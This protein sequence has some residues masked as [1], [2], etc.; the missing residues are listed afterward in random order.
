MCRAKDD[1]KCSRPGRRCEDDAP[2]AVAARGKAY[3]AS[4]QAAELTAAPSEGPVAVLLEAPVDADTRDID[5]LRALSRSIDAAYAGEDR[6]AVKELEAAYGSPMGAV[7]ALGAAVTSRGEELAG[8]TAD[9]AIASWNRRRD[10]AEKNLEDLKGAHAARIDQDMMD[11]DA[12]S[13]EHH[14]GVN[15]EDTE[16]SG[17]LRMLRNQYHSEELTAADAAVTAAE[18]YWEKSGIRNASDPESRA[19]LRKISDGCEAALAEVRALGGHLE[20]HELSDAP[21]AL[22]VTE[23]SSIYPADWVR[24]S[25]EAGPLAAAVTTGR[26]GHNP[27]WIYSDRVAS[28]VPSTMTRPAGSDP[29]D[30][31]EMTFLSV[32][33][34]IGHRGRPDPA[35]DRWTTQMWDVKRVKGKPKG[36]DWEAVEPGVWRRKPRGTIQGAGVTVDMRGSL[37]GRPKG[38]SVAAHE[39]GHHM[40]HVVPGLSSMEHDWLVDRTTV[41][42]EREELVPRWEGANEFVRTDNFL[43]SYIG[44]E[45]TDV[46][47]DSRDTTEVITM[48]V[49]GIFGGDHGGLIGMGSLKRDDDM[50]HFILGSMASAAARKTPDAE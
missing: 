30:T 1:A 46:A 6:G 45:Y 42:G 19:D 34:G 7:R 28:T 50:R 9:E 26:A 4:K 24:A 23:A 14:P 37:P 31:A 27:S 3:Q 18:E 36:Y 32:E 44:R 5:T 41:N 35:Q 33:R 38:F 40:Q 21:A 10:E 47:G 29:K 17:S 20:L 12:W 11:F 22:A 48:G 25:T 13:A 15:W 8:L 2:A 43:D 49:Q 39:L 16:G